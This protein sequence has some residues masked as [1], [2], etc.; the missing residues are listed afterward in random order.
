LKI[1]GN[2]KKI[3]LLLALFPWFLAAQSTDIYGGWLNYQ[4]GHALTI[5][6]DNSFLRNTTKELIHGEIELHDNYMRVYNYTANEEY[7]LY[8][9]IINTT[10]YIEKPNTGQA[11]IFEKIGN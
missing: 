8:Y 11:W 7:D 6:E 3:F 5:R 9:T 4:T 1:F 10:L 2:M